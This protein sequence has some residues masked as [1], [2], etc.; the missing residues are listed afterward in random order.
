VYAHR[1][2]YKLLR[3]PIWTGY[4]PDHLCRDRGCQNPWHMELV[5]HAENGRRG[6]LVRQCSVPVKL[7]L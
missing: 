2:V 7:Q 6:G 4:E 3:G 5:T 1:V